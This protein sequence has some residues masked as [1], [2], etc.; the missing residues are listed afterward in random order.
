MD[1]KRNKSKKVTIVGGGP[2]GALQACYLAKKGYKVDLFEAREDIRND[3]G[4][5]GR[6]IN[7]ALSC[8]G[9]ESLKGVG[10]HDKV[11][12]YG[13][14]MHSRMIHEKD[15][16]CYSVPYGKKGQ[17]L[18]SISRLKLNQV[19]LNEAC[20]LKNIN[21]HFE[22]KMTSCDLNEPSATF[23]RKADNKVVV[24]DD[25]ECLF[26]CDGSYSKVRAQMKRGVFDYMQKY[27]PHAYKELSIPADDNGDFKME[28]GHLHI[29]PRHEY[30]MIALPN[31]DKTWTLTLF[32]PFTVFQPL[33][34]GNKVIQFFKDV[35]PDALPL[36]GE[37]RLVEDYFALKPLPLITVKCKPY[38][39]KN[40][41]A[42]LGDAAH[43][44]VPFYGQG[45]NASLED[46]L[47]FNQI[48]E[49]HNN[50]FETVLPEYS[51]NR[52]PDGQAI[53][54]LSEQNYL[55]MRSDC[56]SKWFL[57]RKKVDNFLNFLLPNYFVPKYTMVSFTRTRYHHVIL[58]TK[59]Q[60]MIVNTGLAMIA[61][62]IFI[63]L[64]KL[65]FLT[66]SNQFSARSFL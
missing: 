36:I 27:I 18:L 4:A 35:F 50:D 2:C 51:E 41:A 64:L 49:E 38:H 55:E 20:N 59:Q 9:I 37:E 16:T 15:G 63:Y 54:D 53:A 44:V 39:Y 60:N 8:R 11:T 40:T 57:F 21:V 47:V 42:L 22:H 32:M 23:I 19:V 28:G 62:F 34:T 25:M 5:A 33:T 30:M 17:H 52:S 3:E 7:L 46:V 1:S 61:A 31:L 45:L 48:M 65:V 6:S 56:A 12:K 29:W 14:P 13:L 10:L 66:P 24:A 58:K 43:S 26:G